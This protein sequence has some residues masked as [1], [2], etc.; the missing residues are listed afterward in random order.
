MLS[1]K[2]VG[3]LPTLPASPGRASSPL[4]RLD[5]LRAQ[6][7]HH[8]DFTGLPVL[9]AGPLLTQSRRANHGTGWKTGRQTGAI[10]AGQQGDR[11]MG[12]SVYKI[13]ELVGTSTESWDRAAAIAVER[14]GKSLRALRIA[15]V[16]SQDLVIEDGKVKAYRTKLKVSFKF[17]D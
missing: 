17:E 2:M 4:A 14:A 3:K 13:I 7:P 12:D 10:S 11:T 8:R 1:G 15:E 16:T 9:S 5:V 6:Y